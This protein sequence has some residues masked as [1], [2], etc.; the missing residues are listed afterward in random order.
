MYFLVEETKEEKKK[1]SSPIPL[2]GNTSFCIWIR[3]QM[4]G[5]ILRVDTEFRAGKDLRE[6]DLTL[7]FV[8]EKT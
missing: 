8:D 1:K 3:R 7:S 4:R 5:I 2:G 6:S